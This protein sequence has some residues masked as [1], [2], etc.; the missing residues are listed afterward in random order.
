MALKSFSDKDSSAAALAE[1][2]S[3]GA[4]IASGKVGARGPGLEYLL[5][6]VRQQRFL[7]LRLADNL[8]NFGRHQGQ[9]TRYGKF[10]TK[11]GG[12]KIIL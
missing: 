12:R 11:E 6:L 3:W 10:T 2:S 1:A 8:G 5:T 4:E 7:R 9:K